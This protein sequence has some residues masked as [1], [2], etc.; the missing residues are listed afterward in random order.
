MAPA[1]EPLDH[2]VSGA[3]I[4]HVELVHP[5]GDEEQRPAA[6]LLGGRRVLDELDEVVAEHHLARRRGDVLPDHE[7][8]RR[9][10]PHV[11]PAGLRIEVAEEVGHAV[12]DAPPTGFDGGAERLRVGGEEVGRRERIDHLPGGE[13]ELAQVMLAEPRAGQQGG[14]GAGV[15]EVRLLQEV[16]PRELVPGPIPEPAVVL[17]RPRRRLRVDAERAGD[18][19]RPERHPRPGEIAPGVGE[20]GGIGREPCPEPPRGAGEVKGI[21]QPAR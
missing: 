1:H 5:R 3:Q 8:V 20:M 13:V 12:E 10:H 9:A 6:Y 2:G 17:V 15:H 14:A 16:E 4:H 21:G 11:E 7:G 18:A 19:V